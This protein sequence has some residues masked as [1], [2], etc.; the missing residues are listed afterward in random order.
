MA[1]IAEATPTLRMVGDVAHIEP[2]SGGSEFLATIPAEIGGTTQTFGD[3]RLLNVT[4]ELDTI[5]RSWTPDHSGIV[6]GQ[7]AKSITVRELGTPSE[8]RIRIVRPG[9]SE[10]FTS[11]AGAAVTLTYKA[12]VEERPSDEEPT[13]TTGTE[14]E[15]EKDAAEKADRMKAIG[16]GAIVIGVLLLAWMLSRK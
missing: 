9:S 11:P 13:T 8:W 10:T 5:F 1:I 7:P 12:P 6:G 2:V 4:K 14:E 15:E 16:S 3:I